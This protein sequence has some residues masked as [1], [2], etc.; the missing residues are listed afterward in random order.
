MKQ[1]VL[2]VHCIYMLSMLGP[3]NRH[4]LGLLLISNSNKRM[5]AFTFLFQLQKSPKELHMHD[6]SLNQGGQTSSITFAGNRDIIQN[7]TA[8]AV[9]CH[10]KVV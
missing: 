3:Y 10:S 6:P 7:R 9:S 2:L 5:F 4:L 1:L 8:E